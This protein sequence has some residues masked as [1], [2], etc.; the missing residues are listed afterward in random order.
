MIRKRGFTLIELLVVIAIIAILAAIL[1]PVFARAREK[2][3][4]NTCMNNL[5]QVAIAIQ[6]YVNDNSSTYFP[7]PGQKSWATYLVNYNGPTIYDCPTLTGTGN[8]NTPEYGFN[9]NL[10]APLTSGEVLAPSSAVLCAD[11][12]KSAFTGAYAI[13]TTNDLEARHNNSFNFVA[14]DGH[15][16]IVAIKAPQTNA[17]GLALKGV[18]LFSS[19]AYNSPVT[20]TQATAN[21]S[22]KDSMLKGIVPKVSSQPLSPPWDPIGKI[23][24][25][26]EYVSYTTPRCRWDRSSD[27]WCEFTLPGVAR[28]NY[29]KIRG[30]EKDTVSVGPCQ[31]SVLDA[32]TSTWVDFGTKTVAL[33]TTV[34]GEKIVWDIRAAETKFYDIKGIKFTV[35]AVMPYFAGAQGNGCTEMMGF[36]VE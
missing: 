30:G 7:D 21:D 33:N 19:G 26:V 1:F 35:D 32:R 8:N 31:V 34:S 36:Y 5:R 14:A 12:K 25:G 11:L 2:A 16:D 13:T 4:Q 10:Y 22:A 17:Q 23:S 6:M 3:R 27:F 29:I 24:D 28:V 18:S 9:K 20:I 15:C